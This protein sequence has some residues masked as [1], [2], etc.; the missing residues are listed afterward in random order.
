MHLQII[1]HQIQ[2]ERFTAEFY[3]PAD[4]QEGRSKKKK[5]T[6]CVIWRENSRRL[7]LDLELLSPIDYH[8]LPAVWQNLGGHKQLWHDSW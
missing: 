3:L 2:V 1:R 5:F 8:L 7:W 6:P 4:I